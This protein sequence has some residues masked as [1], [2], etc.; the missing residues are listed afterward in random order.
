MAQVIPTHEPNPQDDED[1][2]Y[3][4]DGV[5]WAEILALLAATRNYTMSE[6]PRT[7]H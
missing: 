3:G 7:I 1:H 5:P 4:V 6:I 2:T